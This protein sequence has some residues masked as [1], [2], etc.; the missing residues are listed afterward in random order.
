MTDVVV[1]RQDPRVADV[2]ALLEAHLATMRRISPPGHVHALDLDGLTGPDVV[3]LTAREGGRLLG[4]GALRDLGAARAEI[5]S[6]HTAADARGGGVG[7][8][9]L[10]HLLAIASERGVDWIGLETGTQ[11]DFGPARSLYASAGFVVCEPFGA[12]TTNPYST[13]M[14]LST[15]QPAGEARRPFVPGPNP[16]PGGACRDEPLGPQP[17]RSS[18]S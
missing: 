15:R 7:R 9:V 16:Q 4:V 10:D 2:V 3:F 18:G 13:C 11:P 5:K 14:A 12:Y 6:M 8:L 17:D 1:A